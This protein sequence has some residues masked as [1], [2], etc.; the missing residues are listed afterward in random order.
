MT[1]NL[2]EPGKTVI[3]AMVFTTRDSVDST[4]IGRIV[5]NSQIIRCSRLKTVFKENINK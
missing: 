2:L 1:T 3:E 4:V 5:K